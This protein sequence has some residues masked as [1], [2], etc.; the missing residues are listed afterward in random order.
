M[1]H[2]E[3][4]N[5]LDASVLDDQRTAYDR[6]R[7]QCPVAHSKLMSWSLFRHHDLVAVLDDPATFVKRLNE[8]MLTLA[9]EGP[10]KL[11]VPGK[12]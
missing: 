8:L 5:P 11:W 6:M 12:A 9:G 10:S 2:E 7:E 1:S 3:T 4:W